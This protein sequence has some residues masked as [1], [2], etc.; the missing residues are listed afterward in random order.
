METTTK[1]I[2]NFNP[3][4]LFD[5]RY[6]LV[7]RA[8][9]GGFADVWKAEDT[10]RKNRVIALKIYTRLDDEG[11]K[12]MSDEYDETEDI[13]H[14]NLLTGNHFGVMGNIPYLEMRFCEGGNLSGKAGK[15]GSDELHHVVRDIAS[16]LAYLHQEGIVHQDIKPENIL[17]DSHRNRYMLADFGISG[18]SRS[19]LSQSVNKVDTTLSMTES[20]APPEKFSGNLDD[21]APD[22]K[23][24]IFSLGMTILELAAGRLPFDPPMATGREMLYSQGRLRLDF[25]K[26]S[27]PTLRFIVGQCLAYRK[28]DRP[29]AADVLRWLNEGAIADD[30][31][32]PKETHGVKPP[33]TKVKLGDSSGI[34]PATGQEIKPPKPPKPPKPTPN[35][36]PNFKWVYVVI[37]AALVV[38]AIVLIPRFMSGGDSAGSGDTVLLS[39]YD[40][41]YGQWTGPSVDGKPEGEG[42][43]VYYDDD[44]DG[45]TR[46]EGT[47]Q[48][49]KR[50]DDDAVLYYKSGNTYRGEFV[51]DELS[52]GRMTLQADGLYFDGEFKNNQP[53][54]GTWYWTDDGSV[55]SKVVKGKEM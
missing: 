24:D 26:I 52:K 8:G 47:M 6:R 16:G 45:R 3:G 29:T 27:D 23:G 46:Y 30:R 28:A 40:T 31:E 20:Y 43:L 7:K 33:T 53:Y 32:R 35:P 48:Q 42:V 50:V 19:R 41:R 39:D 49:G 13:Q 11:I 22:I 18:K 15:F 17:Y 37:V 4:D 9:S 25:S 12:D 5:G 34:K 38:A 44:A 55:Y 1:Q 2:H 54:S 21:V 14:P 36:N 51:D 10:L